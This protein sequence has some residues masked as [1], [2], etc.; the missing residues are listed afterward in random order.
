M[1]YNYNISFRAEEFIYM[2]V[3]EQGREGLEEWD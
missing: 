1:R 3:L 2:T